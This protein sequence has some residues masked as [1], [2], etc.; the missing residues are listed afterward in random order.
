VATPISPKN[1]VGAVLAT[2]TQS[3]RPP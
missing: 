3:L 1:T 2:T